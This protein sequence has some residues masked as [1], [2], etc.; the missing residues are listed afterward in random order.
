MFDDLIPKT[1]PLTIV[2]YGALHAHDYDWWTT[3]LGW[4]VI[5]L[6]VVGALLALALLFVLA[7]K[8]IYWTAF[9]VTRGAHSGWNE[10]AP[11]SFPDGFKAAAMRQW[12]AGAERWTTR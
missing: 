5:A 4:L 11:R 6:I 12:R 10:P 7:M 8:V 2:E 9:A 3:P 1:K